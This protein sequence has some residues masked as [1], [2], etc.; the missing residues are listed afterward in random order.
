MAIKRR[1]HKHCK[2]HEVPGRHNLHRIRR[3]VAV[4]LRKSGSSLDDVKEVLGHS[5]AH[6]TAVYTK[7]F[8]GEVSAAALQGMA[9]WVDEGA[10]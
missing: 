10:Q 8:M 9:H 3:T 6:T 4:L 7:E 2:A 5:R 1:W